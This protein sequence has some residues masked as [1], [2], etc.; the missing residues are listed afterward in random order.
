LYKASNR[1]WDSTWI[2]NIDQNNFRN[3]EPSIEPPTCYGFVTA[4]LNENNILL[5]GGYCIYR[6][7]NHNET[8][9]QYYDTWIYDYKINNWIQLFPPNHPKDI[10]YRICKIGLNKVLL[11][12]GTI[13]YN[14]KWT[15][16]TWLF[17]LDKNDWTK[18][19][20]DFILNQGIIL[21]CYIGND[22]CL[23]WRSNSGL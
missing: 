20:L 12:G 8:V 17:D 10:S 14:E 13:S 23:I 15:E 4:N 3:A 5:F 9:T 22:S 6:D 18:L 2:Y 1:R 19:E 11:L 7:N 16:E 21:N